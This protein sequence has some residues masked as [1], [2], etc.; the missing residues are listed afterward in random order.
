MTMQSLLDGLSRL[1]QRHALLLFIALGALLFAVDAQRRHPAAPMP[2]GIVAA[3]PVD[4]ARWLEDEV[5]YREAVAR[6]LGE[7][8]LIVRRRLV[9]KMRML[10]EAGVEVAEPDT[11]TLD[12]WIDAHA[13]RYGGFERISFEQVF[14]SRGRNEA[15]MAAAAQALGERLRSTTAPDLAALSDPHPGGN[16]F[17]GASAREVERLFGSAFAQQLGELPVGDWQGPLPTALGLYFVRVHDRRTQAPD[18]AA[19]RE[20][21]LRDYLLEQRRIATELAVADLKARY[22]LAP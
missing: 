11:A 16:R 22:G 1:Q 5:L 17:D 12:A 4:A 19:V 15:R 21:A 13:S 14:L 8:D 6:G 9:Q 2:P 10:L 18:H 20:R 3:D 7:G